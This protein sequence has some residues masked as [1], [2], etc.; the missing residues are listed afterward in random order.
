MVSKTEKMQNFLDW[1]KTVN[2]IYIIT[3]KEFL[4]ILNKM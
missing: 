1:F 4:N 3:N 2:S